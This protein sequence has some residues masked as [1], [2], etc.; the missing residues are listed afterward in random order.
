MCV[1][2]VMVLP[3]MVVVTMMA[4]ELAMMVIARHAVSQIG[5]NR[6]LRSRRKEY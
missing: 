6:A 1:Y 2:M 5:G 3:M 4:M